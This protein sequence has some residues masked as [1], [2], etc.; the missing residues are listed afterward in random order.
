MSLKQYLKVK[1]KQL[2]TVSF[3]LIICPGQL[4][5]EIRTYSIENKYEAAFPAPPKYSGEMG[6][7]EKKHRSYSYTDEANLI[8]YTATFQVGKF[9]FDS[10]SIQ[11]ALSQYAK[12]Q[13]QVVKGKLSS[14]ES[15]KRGDNFSATF[16]VKYQYQGVAVRKY[17]VVS[18][19]NRSFYQWSV[20]D[21]PLISILDAQKI[22][23]KHIKE[24]VI[25]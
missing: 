22:F 12:G 2:I 16:M 3:I 18:Y 15:K 23:K 24:F 25:K 21:F 7:K 6:K 9:D 14:Y 13:A 4:G 5:A 20:Q 8:I 19:S 10:S 11:G 1:F 17:S